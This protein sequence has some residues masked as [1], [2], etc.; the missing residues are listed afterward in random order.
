MGAVYASA[1]GFLVLNVLRYLTCPRALRAFPDLQATATA[2]ALGALAVGIAH[3]TQFL[4]VHSHFGR[5][6]VMVGIMAIA[7]AV[8]AFVLDRRLR[9]AA[10]AY[11][12]GLRPAKGV[13]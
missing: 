5:F 3:Y 10:L 2:V 4:G 1:V 6:A 8:P 12:S 9:N 7:Y 11:W 13:V